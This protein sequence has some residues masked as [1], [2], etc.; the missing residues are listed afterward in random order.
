MKE[1]DIQTIGKEHKIFV[2]TCAFM[3]PKAHFFFYE[4]LIPH[5]KKEN[6]LLVHETAIG[7]LDLLS[8]YGHKEETDK[9]K[10]KE[11][12]QLATNGFNIFSDLFNDGY[13]TDVE[14]DENDKNTDNNYAF[15]FMKYRLQ[16]KLCLIMGGDNGLCKEIVKLNS[17]ESSEFDKS[18]KKQ[19]KGINVVRIDYAGRPYLFTLPKP[20]AKPD[21]NLDVQKVEIL[22]TGIIPSEGDFVFNEIGN[23][24]RL[25]EKINEGEGGE[26]IIYAIDKDHRVLCKIFKERIITDRKIKKLKLMVSNK[27]YIKGVCWPRLI[28]Y[29]EKREPIGYLMNRAGKVSYMF[30]DIPKELSSIIG[31][32]KIHENFPEINTSHLIDVS[33]KIL[34]IIDKM[35]N[36]NVIL[37][38]IKPRNILITPRL[39]IY[40]VDTDSF[41]IE[42]LPGAIG[43]IEYTAPNRLDASYGEYLTTKEDQTFA[44]ATLLFNIF[45]L[46]LFPYNYYGG[47][48]AEENIKKSFFPY[49]LEGKK[50]GKELPLGLEIWPKLPKYIQEA[51]LNY[52]GKKQQMN[53]ADWQYVFLSIQNRLLFS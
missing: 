22:S 53:I 26:G 44:V 45:M 18:G 29:N 34:S 10:I 36:Y 52:F 32:D 1:M 31:K 51:F 7:Q 40:F 39:F 11:T 8:K 24:Y 30:P 9:R 20:F 15:I 46:K 5:L 47:G 16:Y 28:L 49:G 33:L 27:L 3:H 17:S 48:T 21:K 37:S 6:K 35:N 41:Q 23:K 42:N 14:T 13:A 2:D 38:D 19:I 4:T 25:K 43:D 12:K 50:T